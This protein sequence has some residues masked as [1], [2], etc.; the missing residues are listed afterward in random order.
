MR[1]EIP[2]TQRDYGPSHLQRQTDLRERPVPAADR[3]DRI[4]GAYDRKVSRLPHAGRQ[5]IRQIWIRPSPVFV[6]QYPDGG[7]FSLGRPSGG[8]LH[9]AVK[10]TADDDSLTLGDKPPDLSS[11]LVQLSGRRTRSDDGD[12]RIAAQS[13]G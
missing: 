10:P 9:Y 11:L 1:A 7:S 3:D 12:V 2:A 4:G 5:A 8:R 6:R 13:V